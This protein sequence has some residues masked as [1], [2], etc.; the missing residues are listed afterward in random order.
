[1][2]KRH[3]LLVGLLFVCVIG[4]AQTYKM[5][6]LY[7]YSFSKYIQWPTEP[8]HTNFVIGVVGESPIIEPLLKMASLKKVN[9]KIIKIVAF[10]SIEDMQD[11]SILFLPADQS[12]NFTKVLNAVGDQS[13]L[14]VTEKNGLGVKGSAINFVMK[15][16]RLMFE[17]NDE[18]IE[19]ANLKVAAELKKY[20]V[21]L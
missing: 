13:I 18:A 9:N 10:E 20:A 5:H 1:M 8:Q 11:C 12:Q 15:N 14:L 7:M 16:N 17:I 4:N 19:K 3:Y 2:R 6:T 21:K